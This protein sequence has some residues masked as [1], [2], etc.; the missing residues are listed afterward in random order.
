MAML[1]MPLA[2]GEGELWRGMQSPVQRTWSAMAM[3]VFSIEPHLDKVDLRQV[4]LLKQRR[5]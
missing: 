4:A 3:R 5:P 1:R 2:T